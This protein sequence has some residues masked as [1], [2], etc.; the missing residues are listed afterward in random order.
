[1]TAD[2]TR[3]VIRRCIDELWNRGNSD[4]TDQMYAAHCSFHDPTFPVDGV[5]GLRE[6]VR[7]L[8]TAQPDLHM[9]VHD[10][11]VDGDMTATRWTLGGTARGEFR[12]IPGTG[13]TYVMSGMTMDKWDGDRVVEE[14]V[15][16]DAL[17]ALQQIGVIPDMAQPGTPG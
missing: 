5:A 6:Q 2:E 11:L 17:G 4:A 13:K 14:W 1:M 15:N 12:G 10:V 8:R 16:Y 7:G 3:A 9:D